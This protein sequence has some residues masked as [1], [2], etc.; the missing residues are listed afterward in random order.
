MDFQTSLNK[1]ADTLRIQIDYANGEVSGS[2]KMQFSPV[3]GLTIPVTLKLLKVFSNDAVGV[4][5]HV[6]GDLY[7][8]ASHFPKTATVSVFLIDKSSL[9]I[10]SSP[11]TLI[12]K[13][14]TIKSVIGALRQ[15]VAQAFLY[16]DR[17]WST[18]KLPT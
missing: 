1:I 4:M 17:K 11:D 8:V 12:H 2:T 16:K 13:S 10:Q 15:G 7:L 6:V 5:A 3:P 18:L 14:M 9:G